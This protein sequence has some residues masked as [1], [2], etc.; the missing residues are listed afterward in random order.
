[1]IAILLAAVLLGG[2][3]ALSAAYGLLVVDQPAQRDQYERDQYVWVAT[4]SLE[5]MQTAAEMLA[6]QSCDQI[7]LA[8]GAPERR[9]LI[10]AVQPWRELWKQQLLNMDVPQDRIQL[11]AT[12]AKNSH[13]LVR[14]IDHQL[15]QQPLA[16]IQVISTATLSRYYQLVIDQALPADRVERYAVRAIARRPLEDQ[17]WW[18]SRNGVERIFFDALRT[19]FVAVSGESEDHPC[20]R[21]QHLCPELAAR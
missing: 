1:M 3:W 18:R 8:Q 21:Y 7:L 10:G 13:E 11:M 20:D 2:P 14:A 12:E 9:E 4:P 15:R 16:Q 19:F 6:Q 17:S 5:C